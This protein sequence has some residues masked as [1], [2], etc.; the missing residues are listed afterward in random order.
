MFDRLKSLLSSSQ[1]GGFPALGL[2]EPAPSPLVS[3]PDTVQHELPATVKP[4]SKVRHSTGITFPVD[5]VAPASD[6]LWLGTLGESL[7]IRGDA[8]ILI[9]PDRDVPALAPEGY[10][11]KPAVGE[12]R[13]PLRVSMR[14]L[15]GSSSISSQVAKRQTF[16]H[17]LIQ[18]V[19]I[20][21]SEHRP[22]SISPD[23]IWL[24]I[25]QGFG[26]H[27]QENAEALR[28]RIVRHDGKKELWVKTESLNPS[29]WPSF[30]SEFSAQIKENSDPVL[31]ETLLCEFSTTTPTIRTA[32][33]VALMDTYQRYFDYAMMC[34][35][36][37][38]K[39][40][41]EGTPDDWQRMRDRIE[42]LATYDL[43]WWTSRLAP[44]LDQFIA[45]AKGSPDRAFW[46]A[47]YKPQKF[48]VTEMATGW[49][50]DLF[51]YLFTA[52]NRQPSLDGGG[53]GLCDSPAQ[54]RNPILN[55]ERINWLPAC[56]HHAWPIAKEP[57]AANPPRSIKPESSRKELT[58]TK[59][60]EGKIAPSPNPSS[61]LQ[62]PG[63]DLK[64]FPSGLSRAPVKIQF[65]DRTRK[66]VLFTGGFFGVSQRPEDNGL[67]P[68]I[69]WAVV[70]KTPS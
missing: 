34:V 50:A 63:V 46:Q 67:S 57:V 39:I 40:T 26:H 56:S 18:A 17:P 65:P 68:I 22:L 6:S 44:I 36:G 45:T 32:C 1:R 33:E 64:S 58:F 70:E 55:G 53:R 49:I 15:D 2:T 60:F 16:L 5:D 62:V 35:C 10:S 9:M 54:R 52:P 8:S 48:Y 66:E 25:V 42:V 69:S 19:H 12:P 21:F 23:C 43:D 38:P 37:I 3:R 11:E 47:I 24:T 31:H 20:A 51:P 27:V 4:G 61:P 30:I 13:K 28:S 7:E 41:L 29:L 59:F 14:H